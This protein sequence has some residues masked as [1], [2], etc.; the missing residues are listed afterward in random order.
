[1]LS[2]LFADATSFGQI[3]TKP[4]LEQT[5]NWIVEK[6]N[7]YSTDYRVNSGED[8]Y[9]DYQNYKFSYDDNKKVIVVSYKTTTYQ[10]HV[11]PLVGPDISTKY[12]PVNIIN[13]IEYEKRLSDPILS[14]EIYTEY[15][16][17]A[18]FGKS[19]TSADDKDNNYATSSIEFP[20]MFDKEDNL[21]N[22]MKKAFADLKSYF[23]QKKEA[24]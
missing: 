6:L 17:I 12:I 18:V 15:L 4:T 2:I 13:K 19:I 14:S 16:V 20:F 10:R 3:K 23:P 22:R 11:R 5:I 24:Y 8:Y 7:S 21:L 1:M 9:T